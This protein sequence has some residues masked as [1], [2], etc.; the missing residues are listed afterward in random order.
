MV[1][2]D[3]QYG[4]CK[5]PTSHAI[6]AAFGE[7]S[8]PMND[9]LNSNIGCRSGAA[10]DPEPHHSTEDVHTSTASYQGD[11][12]FGRCKR[13]EEERDSR[14]ATKGLAVPTAS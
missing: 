12:G 13:V 2:T 9:P 4:S 7:P 5:Y 6:T 11:R 10:Q 3:N 14:Q 1:T 8:Q